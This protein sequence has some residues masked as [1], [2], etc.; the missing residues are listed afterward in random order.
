MP[1]E[2]PVVVHHRWADLPSQRISESLERK[3][4]SAE[5]FTLAQFTLKGGAT[6]PAHAHEQ[7]QMSWVLQGTLKITMNGREIVVKEG[8]VLQIPAWMEHQ[9]SVLE[10]ALVVDVFCPVRQDWKS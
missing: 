1:T 10:D 2:Q 9:V 4:I 8:E 3:F 7:E 6:Y 5:R